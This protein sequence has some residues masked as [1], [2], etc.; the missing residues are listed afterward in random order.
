MNVTKRQQDNIFGNMPASLLTL[1]KA[2][3]LLTMFLIPLS[4]A[5]EDNYDTFPAASGEEGD[6]PQYN[7]TQQYLRHEFVNIIVVRNPLN[8][9]SIQLP[10][11]G[12]HSIRNTTSETA[13]FR[14]C[15][16]ATNAGF[17][18]FKDSTCLGNLISDSQMINTCSNMVN[19]GLLNNGSF[20][21]GYISCET[22]KNLK[23]KQLV[24][25][26]GWLV[27]DSS[28]YIGQS[29]KIERIDPSF[30]KWKCARVV[31]GH[32]KYGR[33]LMVE[34]D[35]VCSTT[36]VDLHQLAKL[37]MAWCRECSESGW[38]WLS[39]YAHRWNKS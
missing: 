36:G 37:V 14:K 26:I 13:K 34:V 4:D 18:E 6:K 38:S 28:L 10:E 3:I 21:A 27:R 8:H 22:M 32:D 17:F 2:I 31:I 24:S 23:I 20:I 15:E 1:L 30:V 16:A 39:H 5:I 7:Y 25:G 29:I 33:L 11:H 12:C 19:F 9:F 35:G